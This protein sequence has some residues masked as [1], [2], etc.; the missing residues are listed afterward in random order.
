MYRAQGVRTVLV[1]CT[2]GEEGDLHNP[3]L[4]DEGGPFHGLTPE[5]EGEKL[6]E[7]RMAE[8]A[9]S[10]RI[11]GF[12][13]VVMLPYRDSGMKDSEANQNPDSFHQADVDEAT[14]HL[15]EVIRRERPQVLITYSDDQ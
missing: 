3:K 14:G 7:V 13:E 11:I 1:C 8:L 10:A 5:Q 4:R 9:E 6:A 12:S 2:G 15:V